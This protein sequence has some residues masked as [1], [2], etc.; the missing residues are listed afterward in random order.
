[1][2][3]RHRKI[4]G[5]DVLKEIGTGAASVLYAVQDPKTKQIWA[6]KHVVKTT[7]KDQ[8]FLEQA[9]IEYAV[10]SKLGHANVRAM[11]RLVKIRKMLKVTEIALVMELVDA[12]P[13]D[14]YTIESPR[15][16][17]D[18]FYQI[19]RGLTHMHEQGY[20]HADMKPNNVLV[21]DDRGVKIIDLGQACA[22]GA[23]KKR[24]QGTPGYMA[25]EQ[26]HRQAI[27]GQTDIYN[28]G[29]TMY[30]A[31]CRD[32]IPTALP[33]KDEQTGVYSGALDA[34][35][36]ELPKP[37]AERNPDAHP[38]LSQL[39][40]DCV[41]LRPE[42]RPASMAEVR[43]TL[44]LIRDLLDHADEDGELAPDLANDETHY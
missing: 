2:P 33:P 41:Q 8:R 18:I 7:D 16:L 4:A 28:F 32:V 11:E 42:D 30:W 5:Y 38:R 39:V 35:Q 31:L 25:P 44:K 6:L 26:A 21:C 29:A 10:A 43:D 15:R 37:P 9:E 19:A 13:L 27:T 40:M 20:V 22:V 14:Q 23:V 3:P 12:V 17:V 34:D 24:I 36:V 1:M